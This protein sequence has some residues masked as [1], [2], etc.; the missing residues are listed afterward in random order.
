MI[1]NIAY[2]GETKYLEEI[3][4]LRTLQN[5]TH[6]KQSCHSENITKIAERN[7]WLDAGSGRCSNVNITLRAIVKVNI[8]KTADNYGKGTTGMLFII[9][10]TA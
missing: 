9:Y 2:R 1:C 8:N 7:K 5:G 6:N 10:L 4:E 3:S